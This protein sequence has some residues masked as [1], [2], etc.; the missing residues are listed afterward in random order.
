MAAASVSP[1]IRW[2]VRTF[3][4]IFVVCGM[5]RIEA[6]PLT[7][8]RLFSHVRKPVQTSW[9]AVVVAPSGSEHGMAF[10]DAA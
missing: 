3:L 2:F 9:R 4:L 10:A 1:R 6:W 8:W 7:G 5:A